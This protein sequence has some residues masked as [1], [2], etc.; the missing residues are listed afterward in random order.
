MGHIFLQVRRNIAA[1][2]ETHEEMKSIIEEPLQCCIFTKSKTYT[3]HL[4]KSINENPC[5]TWF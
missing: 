1:T 4:N 3:H 5:R 2:K